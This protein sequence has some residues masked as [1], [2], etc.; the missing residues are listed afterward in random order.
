MRNQSNTG[1]QVPGMCFNLWIMSKAE[2][3]P[4]KTRNEQSPVPAA[5]T[6]S[7]KTFQ[8]RAETGGLLLSLLLRLGS[9]VGWEFGV[10]NMKAQVVSMVYCFW[11]TILALVGSMQLSIV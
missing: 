9:D 10:N 8:W 7:F 1:L 4:S 3:S 6:I 5:I 11:C 2:L